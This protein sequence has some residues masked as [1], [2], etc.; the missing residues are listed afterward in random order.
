MPRTADA[1]VHRSGRTAR[2]GQQGSSILICSPEEAAGVRKLVAK[3]HATAS[4]EGDTAKKQGYFVHT[5]D[6]DRRLVSK[7]RQRAN[8]AK[9]LVR[10]TF[11]VIAASHFVGWRCALN[12]V[13]SLM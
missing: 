13:R 2:A 5:L 7:L 11:Y 9:K 4:A 6:V 12:F 1:Y 10:I 8:L 3:V